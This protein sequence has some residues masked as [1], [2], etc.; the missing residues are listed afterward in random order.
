MISRPEPHPRAEP[1]VGTLGA[2]SNLRADERFVV[3][4]GREAFPL[5]ANTTAIPLA[6]LTER[7]AT[8]GRP[9]LALREPVQDEGT[10]AAPGE[11]AA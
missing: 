6:D 7:L 2:V 10:A 4:P 3:H 8:A 5:S 9:F 11:T 1:A